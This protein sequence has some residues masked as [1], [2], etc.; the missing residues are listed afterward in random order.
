MLS[1]PH[2]G[3]DR[4]LDVFM[5]S[6][7]DP[8]DIYHKG[9]FRRLARTVEVL[10]KQKPEGS[11]LEV[12]TSKI[13]PITLAKFSPDLKVSVTD[14]DLTKPKKG[15]TILSLN[16]QEVK[17]PCFRVD[18]ENTPIP[19]PDETFDYVLCCEVLEH[20]E[21]DPMF[22]LAELN[23]VLKQNGTLILTTPNVVSSRGITKMLNGIEP[24]FYMHYTKNRELHR[25]NYEYSIYSL[26][27]L[28]KAAGFD[29]S[30][31]TEDTFE[32]PIHKDIDRLKT[33][34]YNL[35]HLGDNLFTVARKVSKVLD[36]QPDWMYS[37]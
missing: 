15:S 2:K 24:Y 27:K 35:Q 1:D 25:H 28:I 19:V 4:D 26:T 20:M 5:S 18:L 23:R 6:L 31:W 9:H 8:D 22:M 16:G 30:A 32:D 17:V 3:I 11:L 36:M 21:I 12:G 14:F 33:A 37:D 13:V 10:L 34:G 29:G 7:I